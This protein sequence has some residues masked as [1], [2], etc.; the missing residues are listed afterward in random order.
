MQ[1]TT[2]LKFKKLIRISSNY[3]IILRFFKRTK[4]HPKH[5]LENIVVILCSSEESTIGI[6]KV[7][8]KHIN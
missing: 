8:S 2:C 3:N 5:H 4:D 1:S 6:D 7:N